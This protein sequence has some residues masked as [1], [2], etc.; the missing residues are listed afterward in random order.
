MKTLFISLAAIAVVLACGLEVSGPVSEYFS[1]KDLKIIASSYN[2]KLE[3]RAVLYGNEQAEAGYNDAGHKQKQGAIFKLYT[4]KESTDPASYDFNVKSTLLKTE[5]VTIKNSYPDS[6]IATY[7]RVEG[8][9]LQKDSAE[10]SSQRISSITRLDGN[11]LQ[12]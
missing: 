12:N 2:P 3:T 5:I 11:L 4:Y 6:I 7:N 8:R 10:S 9:K 1:K